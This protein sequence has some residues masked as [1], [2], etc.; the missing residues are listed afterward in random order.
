M[1][2]RNSLLFILLAMT[3]LAQTPAPDTTVIPPVTTTV[4]VNGT[5]SSETPAAITLLDSQQLQQNAGV[6]MDDKLRQVPGFSLFRRSS[7][8]AANPTTQGV[9]L[10]ATGSN[11]A[12]R[13]LVL[14]DDFPIN[15]PFGGWV[16][17]DRV[18]P[19]YVQTVEIVRGASTSIFGDG[20]LGGA[21][22]M[23]SPQE[24]SEHLFGDVMQGSSGI[25]EAALGY[26]NLWGKWGL[27]VHSRGFTSSSYYIVPNSIRG[28]AD[29]KADLHYATGDVHLDYLGTKDRLSIY[30]N[31][32]AEERNNGTVKTKNSSA[33]GTV[34]AHYTHSWTS[35]Q[36]SGIVYHTQE[37]FH[38]NFSSVSANRATET[39]TSKQ[40][41]PVNDN[42]GAAYWQHLA[43]HFHT[44]LGTD[45]D[46]VHGTSYD[47]SFSTH[48][49]TPN[50]GVL[51]KHGEFGEGDLTFG[52]L[53]LFA[54]IRQQFTG[55]HGGTF[56]SPNGGATYAIQR[57]RLRASGY[58]SFRAPTL[59]ELYRPF[60]VGN[61]QTA[62]NANLVPE[63]VVGVETGA[64]W[65][66]ESTRAGFT[67]FHNDLYNLIDNVT[68]S[69]T[70]TTILRQRQNLP[71][72]LSR[73][74]EANLSHHWRRWSAEAS[75]IY[76][77]ARLATGYRIAEIPKQNGTAQVT[78]NRKGTLITTGL[79]AVSLAFDD[80]LNQFRL[81]GYATVGLTG[82]Q[83]LTR[84]L[85]AVA[86][87]DNLL[88][89]TYIVAL[90]PNPNIG[91]P[92][93][94]QVGLRWSGG[95]R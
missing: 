93:I 26:S 24:S 94:W 2:F 34:G 70:P 90:T 5:I 61:V 67:L 60:R 87:V 65:V 74:L 8:L 43:K 88:D 55:L 33:I 63:S 50:G 21:I 44:L 11:G 4:T 83:K 18:D 81:P 30:L 48:V 42:G 75:Y 64:D 77:D 47:Y 28:A 7:S 45:W 41:V 23:R 10:R 92:L 38:S 59:N 57:F 82:Q 9:S 56:V 31:I 25:G 54:G 39:L 52:G 68:I 85:S 20:A 37:Q 14:L 17:W 12:S 89:K 15:D 66:G 16:Y 6:E 13:T 19:N 62:A 29:D 40:T 58:K 72:A 91:T 46:D 79:R 22:S 27:D 76:A 71:Q 1:W 49:L 95:I 53:K 51:V 35:D 69:T 36:V 84:G 3:V 73:G 32:L 80:S 86:S 78:F